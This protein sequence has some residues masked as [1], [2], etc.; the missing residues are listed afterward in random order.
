[1][2]HPA[3]RSPAMYGRLQTGVSNRTAP[4]TVGENI[5]CTSSIWWWHSVRCGQQT[6]SALAADEAPW[7]Y[8]LSRE[9]PVCSRSR[10]PVSVRIYLRCSPEKSLSGK[11]RMTP[12]PWT[13]PSCCFAHV[14]P[15]FSDTLRECTKEPALKHLLARFSLAAISHKY[16]LNLSKEFSF[17]KLRY[18]GKYGP[19]RLY[20]LAAHFCGP[21]SNEKRRCYAQALLCSLASRA[22]SAGEAPVSST[23]ETETVWVVSLQVRSRPGR[24]ASS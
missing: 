3:G 18:K 1:M 24:S 14:C 21:C 19:R 5:Q 16:G 11:L 20:G 13:L 7:L 22:T 2:L 8:Q 10:P 4:L 17:P 15:S 23:E 9:D 12:S 6:A